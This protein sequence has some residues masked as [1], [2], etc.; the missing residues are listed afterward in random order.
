M[1]MGYRWNLMFSFRAPP[2]LISLPDL[3]VSSTIPP[4][5]SKLPH[6]VH[7]QFKMHAPCA[8][9]ALASRVT[10]CPTAN[11][12]LSPTSIIG[13]WSMRTLRHTPYIQPCLQL[14][15][16]DFTVPTSPSLPRHAPRP[17]TTPPIN[18][19]IP[20]SPPKT[21]RSMPAMFSSRG[22]RFSS[23]TS[24]PYLPHT[25]RPFRAKNCIRCVPSALDRIAATAIHPRGS[26]FHPA[27]GS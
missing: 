11:R 8:C 26:H 12:S 1:D 20:D 16:P 22:T 23:L 10:P 13:R 6:A 9:A 18:A 27:C 25:P 14:T 7:Y 4:R 3:T 15:K 24:S 19:H 17:P 21:T 2:S 5:P